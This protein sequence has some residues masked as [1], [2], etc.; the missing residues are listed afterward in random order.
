VLTRAPLRRFAPQGCFRTGF[1]ES[2]TGS[3][4][5]NP[6]ILALVTV[7]VTALIS[8]GGLSALLSWLLCFLFLL[9]SLYLFSRTLRFRVPFARYGALSYVAVSLAGLLCLHFYRIF[10]GQD[11]A[12]YFDDS[13]YFERARDIAATGYTTGSSLF[14]PLVAGWMRLIA[15]IVDQPSLIHVL[16]VSWALAGLAAALSYGL[17]ETISG[18][19]LPI[20]SAAASLLGNSVFI[21]S[22]VHLYRDGLMLVFFML[23]LLASIK[24]RWAL[25]L[26]FA[27]LCGTVRSANAFLC[28]VFAALI[29]FVQRGKTLQSAVILSCT[30]VCVIG[31]VLLVDQQVGFVG[32]G[33]TFF[34]AEGVDKTLFDQMRWRWSLASQAVSAGESDSA[35]YGAGP[36]AQTLSPIVSIFSP[37]HV[38]PLEKGVKTLRMTESGGLAY[39]SIPVRV[40]S[41]FEWVTV[42]LWV[43]VWPLLVCG[44]LAGWHGNTGQ[45]AFV[46]FF[47]LTVCAVTALSAQ[48]RHKDAYVILFP[49]IMALAYGDPGRFRHYRRPITWLVASF[50]ILLNVRYL[51]TNFGR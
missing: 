30:C 35:L 11:F 46:L 28:L 4:S 8:L 3:G 33:R 37:I 25:A 7:D 38:R 18:V 15:P 2:R 26:T 31:G 41:I 24:R 45:R 42:P 6:W 10:S 9:V 12:P 20:A 17:S 48:T 1:V 50:L 51:I 14:E 40:E 22:T 32:R 49:S 47:L 27:L 16:P 36:A 21:D 29:F 23:S 19:K 13:M 43:L 34:A 5:L 44:I 39:G